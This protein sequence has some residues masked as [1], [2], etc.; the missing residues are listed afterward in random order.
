MR[1]RRPARPPGMGLKNMERIRIR[2]RQFKIKRMMKQP[3]NVE[4][5]R[6]GR[7]VRRM[8]VRRRTVYPG[9]VRRNYYYINTL[10]VYFLNNCKSS[11]THF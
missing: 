3:R 2:N 1:P 5:K 11:A 10:T 8:V 4:V 7:V 6:N 9:E